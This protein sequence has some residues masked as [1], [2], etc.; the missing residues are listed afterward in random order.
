[1][2]YSIRPLERN[3][4]HILEKM[5]YEAI[6]QPDETNSIPREVVELPEIRVYID[7]F[8]EKKDD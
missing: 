7:N 6:Y 5:L 4:Y 2:K 3:E 1:M 8:G